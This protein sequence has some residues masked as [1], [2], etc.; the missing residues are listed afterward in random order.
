M[1]YF[2]RKQ[3]LVPKYNSRIKMLYFSSADNKYTTLWLNDY[4][5][6][7]KINQKL[8]SGIRRIKYNYWTH[9]ENV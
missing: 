4:I 3:E 7:S 2:F 8:Q 9:T 1:Y 5:G 6:T